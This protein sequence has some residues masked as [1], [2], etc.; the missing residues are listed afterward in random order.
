MGLALKSP[1]V[2]LLL[3]LVILSVYVICTSLG[4]QRQE[5]AFGLMARYSRTVKEP[6]NNVHVLFWVIYFYGLMAKEIMILVS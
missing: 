3:F 5:L 4:D 2:L 6:R 1:V